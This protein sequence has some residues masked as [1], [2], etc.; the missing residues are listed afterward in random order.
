[1]DESIGGSGAGPVVDDATTSRPR[2][3]VPERDPSPLGTTLARL[4]GGAT[5]VVLVL[6][7]DERQDWLLPVFLAAVAWITVSTA[8]LLRRRW[9]ILQA[10]VVGTVDLG[11]IV[12]AIVATGHTESPVLRTLCLAPAAWAV[13]TDRVTTGLLIVLG[14]MAFG[15][16]WAIDA[17]GGAEQPWET[18][19]TF[20]SIYLSS[21]AV[22]YVALRLRDDSRAQAER[23]A[24]ARRKLTKELGQVERDERERLAVQLHDGPLQTIISARQDLVDHLDG[25]PDALE[26]G[27][28]T[29]DESIVSLRSVT[30]DVFP[31]QD[32]G[33]IVR[34]QL[35][36]IVAAWETRGD[37]EIR[38]SLD[39]EV[40]ERSD[41]ML[42]GMVAELIGNAA[43]HAAPT[44]VRVDLRGVADGVGLQV[45]DDG[46]GMTPADRIHAEETGHIGLRSLNRRIQAVGGRLQI[47]SAPGRGTSVRVL[48]PR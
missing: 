40:A 43:K 3:G 28:A 10:R 34:E 14:G 7:A 37:F 21:S 17:R 42:V 33:S 4:A 6:V 2:P 24:E 25:D 35:R 15:V 46:S 26:I 13:I 16:M 12:L 20:A 27:I 39:E 23:L 36:S 47:R 22:A 18:F 30:T 32:G 45:T 19:A 41:P 31:D 5:M 44:V 9:S 1:M 38:V 48:L 8:H 11:I 29:L